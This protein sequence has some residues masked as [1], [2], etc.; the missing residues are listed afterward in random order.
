MKIWISDLETVSAAL[1]SSEDTLSLGG[2]EINAE[3]ELNVS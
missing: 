2:N 3:A 1:F